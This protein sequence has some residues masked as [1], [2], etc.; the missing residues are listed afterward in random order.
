MLHGDGDKERPAP[1]L[2]SKER[3]ARAGDRGPI[4]LAAGKAAVVEAA[5]VE[6]ASTVAAAASAA[7]AVGEAGHKLTWASGRLSRNHSQ[8]G[9]GR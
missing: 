6:A 5:G 9:V 7:A 4:A 8:V 3:V 1:P 2:R